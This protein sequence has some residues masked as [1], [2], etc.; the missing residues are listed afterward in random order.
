MD[1]NVRQRKYSSPLNSKTG[2][3]GKDETIEVVKLKR[4]VRLNLIVLAC[5]CV[6]VVC[7]CVCVHVCFWPG[8]NR[9]TRGNSTEFRGVTQ[10]PLWQFRSFRRILRFRPAR[11]RSLKPRNLETAEF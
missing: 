8:R 1:S 4:E 7:V 10:I 5:V 11:H 9:G 3:T 6:S 2:I